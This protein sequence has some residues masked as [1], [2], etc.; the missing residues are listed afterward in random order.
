MSLCINPRCTQPDNPDS[1]LFCQSCGSEMLLQGRY[2]VLRLLGEGGF[3]MTY[4][5]IGVRSSIPKVLK[6][7]TNNT[8][9]AVELFQQEAQV[10][11]QLEHPGIPKVERD[12]YFVYLPRNSQEPIHCLVMEKI[13]GMDLEKYMLNREMRSIE[14][15][16][17][18]DW[19]KEIV[20]ILDKVH[21]QNFFHRDIKPSNIMLRSSGEL[22][23][24]DFGTARQV[25]KTVVNQ[26]G[27]VT[28]IISAGFT[29]QEQI[30][31]NAVP[32]SDFFALGRTFVYLLTGKHP[33]DQEI[34]DS[35]NDEVK[36]RQHAPQMSPKIADLID[37]MMSHKANQRPANAKV[38][39]SML[40]EIERE[41][42]S[43]KYVSQPKSTHNNIPETLVNITNKENNQ[44]QTSSIVY[45]AIWKRIFAGI[46]D[47][48]ICFCCG[49]L[50]GVIVFPI[51]G[52]ILWNMRLLPS[53]TT[54]I[55]YSASGSFNFFLGAGFFL[56]VL[57]FSWLYYSLTESSKKQATFGQRI[58]KI[59]I[60]DLNQKN[61]FFWHA[62][63]KFIVSV[64]ITILIMSFS[65][66]LFIFGILIYFGTASF[67]KKKRTL[68]DIIT[69]TMVINKPN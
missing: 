44:P 66:S 58:F 14:P 33:I 12:G 50:T 37:V 38:I 23:L 65:Q 2:R 13:V 20:I 10:L 56:G 42:Y 29:P 64:I 8:P 61:I 57:I 60:T 16:L 51:F 21:S 28:G 39:L 43:P 5:V 55:A 32:Q 53:S 1:V 62:T 3:G 48:I 34:Y 67:N 19:L 46:I 40:A 18:I 7:L 47:L 52:F 45:A 11:S 36:W 26:Q 68:H 35:F 17:A 25:T 15:T 49:G 24:I 63:A 41:L 6:V 9:K 31:N 59:I 54:G 69:G 27:G 30:Y 22:A 4:E